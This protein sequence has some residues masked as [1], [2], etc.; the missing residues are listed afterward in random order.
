MTEEDIEAARSAKG[1]FTKQTLASWGVPWPPPKG[2]KE[3]LIAGKTMA[4]AGL[5]TTSLQEE[6]LKAREP[7]PI[8]Q[9]VSAHDLLRKVVLAVVNAGHASDLYKY[10][11]VLAYF[12][13]K[14]PDD[15]P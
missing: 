8:R 4:E 14:L 6:R 1:G 10:P 2:W 11:D 5:R 12:G 13:A 7:S 9:D 3:A 15:A